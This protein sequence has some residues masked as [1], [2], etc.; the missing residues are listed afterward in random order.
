MNRTLFF[1]AAWI[2][3]VTVQNIFATEPET[4]KTVAP[5][6]SLTEVY[7]ADYFFEGP[8][9]DHR[10][11]RLYFTAFGDN[12]QQILRL[13]A[14]R[15]VTVWMDQTQGVNGTYHSLDGRLLGAQAHGHRVVSYAF[16]QEGPEDAKTLI[17]SDLWHQPNDICQT[18]NGDIYFT[19]PD[20]Q[21]RETS[22]V[23]QLSSEGELSKVVTDMEVPNGVIASIDGRTL[24]VG[25]SHFKRWRSYPIASDG[26]VGAGKVFFDP[27]T[28][29]M[30][31]P[32]GMSIDENGNLYLSGRG[33]VWVA[34]PTGQSLGLIPTAEFCSNV[35][36]GGNDGK[37][38]FMT[39]NKKVYSLG[40][41]VRGGQFRE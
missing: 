34:S 17:G 39:C 22:A 41:S 21:K 7:A 15:Q 9:W 36:F 23:F 40:M 18:P 8:T 10:G 31:S 12:S 35:T 4:A 2:L 14:P 24:Y 30:S 32:D 26:T 3:V 1:S 28:E 5:D 11:Q 19:D 25:D 16:G 29:N 27:D 6:A 38:L 37:T 33:G 20:F 13:D